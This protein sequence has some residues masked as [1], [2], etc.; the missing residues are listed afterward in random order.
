MEFRNDV[1][2]VLRRAVF[3]FFKCEVVLAS[4]KVYKWYVQRQTCDGGDITYKC[5]IVKPV[6]IIWRV[7]PKQMLSKSTCLRG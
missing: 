5:R 6:D 4:S 2:C 3:I 1:N 7:A